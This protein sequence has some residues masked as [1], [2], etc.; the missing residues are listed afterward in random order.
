M[1]SYRRDHHWAFAQGAGQQFAKE[2][3]ITLMRAT[4]ECTTHISERREPSCIQVH[5]FR[6]NAYDS[7]TLGFGLMRTFK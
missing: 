7:F 6:F 3:D 2:G 1:A 4:R 5:V